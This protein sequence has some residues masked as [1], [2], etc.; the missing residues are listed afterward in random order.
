MQVN[1]GDAVRVSIWY[2]CTPVHGMMLGDRVGTDFFFELY[3][4]RQCPFYAHVAFL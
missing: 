3:T 4:D 1:P 2:P